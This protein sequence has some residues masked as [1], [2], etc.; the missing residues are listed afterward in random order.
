MQ[1][2]PLSGLDTNVEVTYASAEIGAPPQGLRSI[3]GDDAWWPLS[4]A[5]DWVREQI[6]P[7]LAATSGAE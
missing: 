7:S 5:P 6:T 3:V 2:H 4:G 1:A